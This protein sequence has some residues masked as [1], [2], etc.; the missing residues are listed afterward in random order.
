VLLTSRLDL[1]EKSSDQTVVN[2][3]LVC[4]LKYLI[5]HELHTYMS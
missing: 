5:T 1:K 4:W 3:G 2:N